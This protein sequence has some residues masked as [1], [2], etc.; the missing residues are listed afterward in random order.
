MSVLSHLLNWSKQACCFSVGY[1]RNTGGNNK[2]F[3]SVTY[4]IQCAF[5]KK[6]YSTNKFPTVTQRKRSSAYVSAGF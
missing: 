1:S 6:F 3:N 5:G 2:E 4:S